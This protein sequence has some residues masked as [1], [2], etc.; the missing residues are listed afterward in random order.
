MIINIL[1]EKSYII[2]FNLF[3]YFSM[4]KLLIG[5]VVTQL[6]NRIKVVKYEHRKRCRRFHGKCPGK[7][8]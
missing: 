6:T 7:R 2:F 1:M 3:F 5:L 8:S 4:H